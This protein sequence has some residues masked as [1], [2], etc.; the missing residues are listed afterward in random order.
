MKLSALTFKQMFDGYNNH[1]EEG[2][3]VSFCMNGFCIQDSMG[4]DL[5]VRES[6]FSSVFNL[7][8]DESVT[9]V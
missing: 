1:V 7:K 4:L 3:T 8:K 9:K 5:K 6:L 2:T